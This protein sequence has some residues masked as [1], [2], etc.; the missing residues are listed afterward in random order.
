MQGPERRACPR[1]L[2]STKQRDSHPSPGLARHYITAVKRLSFDMQVRFLEDPESRPP[3][4]ELGW[5]PLLNM[6][7]LEAFKAAL[8]GQR[9]AIKAL[10]LDQAR[11]GQA[12]QG[13]HGMSHGMHR[14]AGRL[15]RMSTI[16][17][18]KHSC[19]RVGPAC[20]HGVS[21]LPS[22]PRA[23]LCAELQC[24]CGQLGSRRGAV[25]GGHAVISFVGVHISG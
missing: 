22:V 11:G 1:V 19:L 5:D 10:L 4:S 9:R 3:I 21:C 12:C 2:S 6:P 20:L 13:S 18:C 8:A 14:H 23:W 24:G 17:Q 25:P 7:A 15:R 16:A